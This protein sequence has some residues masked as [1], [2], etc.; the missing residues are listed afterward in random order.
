MYSRLKGGIKR[1]NTVNFKEGQTYI[2]KSDKLAWW[3]LGKEYKVQAFSNGDLYI[4]DDEE[5][6][7]YLNNILLNQVF[8][9]KEQTFD[10]NKLTTEQL[11]EY[12]GLLEE[13]EESES[14]LNEFIERM[15]K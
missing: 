8:K 14:L 12:I 13:K 5:D 6:K 10:L 1:M 7:W 3:T 9:L 4:T 2:C 15:S 11:R